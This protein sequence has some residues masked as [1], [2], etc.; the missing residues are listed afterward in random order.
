MPAAD[1]KLEDT[2]AWLLRAVAKERK[3]KQLAS[4]Q[5]QP[6]PEEARKLDEF[7]GVMMS[8]GSREDAASWIRNKNHAL[9][10][11]DWRGS[12]RLVDRFLELGCLHVYAC[13]ID[14][15]DEGANTG[16][17]VL[18]LPME[19]DARAKVLKAIG[20]VASDAGYEGPF[21]D[22][23]RYGYVKLD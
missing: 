5:H 2:S 13:K 15:C 17:L 3:Q 8:Q 16:H 22:S 10:E 6:D 11:R 14:R 12:K 9:G 7:C 4:K 21:D 18:E 20:R 23:Q 19:R 1:E